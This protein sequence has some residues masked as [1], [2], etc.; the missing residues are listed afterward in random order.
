ME[1]EKKSE[2]LLESG[3]NEVEMLEFTVSNNH[4]GV[5][6]S[7]V[8]RILQYDKSKV[9]E[10]PKNNGTYDNLIMIE[11]KTVPLLSMNDVLKIPKVEDLERRIVMLLGFNNVQVAVLVDH[12]KEIHRISWKE[13]VPINDFLAKNTSQ[14]VTG[15]FRPEDEDI[16]VIDFEK[17]MA[18]YFPECSIDAN[19]ESE[20]AED[21]IEFSRSDYNIFHVD[22]SA[23]IRMLFNKNMTE[24][25]YDNITSFING[26]ECY[27]KFKEIDALIKT[28]ECKL[29]DHVN[30]VIIDIEMPQMDG[31]TLCR[32]IRQEFKWENLYVILFSSLVDSQMADKCKAVGASTQISKPDILKLAKK[33]DGHFKENLKDK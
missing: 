29:E 21:D 22:D 5:N 3:T 24:G 26:Q 9:T 4:F 30:A 8:K 16:V 23:T 10:L 15:T 1:T 17:I 27:E 12:I 25:G 7:K 18:E 11:N 13:F 31:L 19:W 33:L 14:T 32:K 28:G 6:V 20:R 2:I